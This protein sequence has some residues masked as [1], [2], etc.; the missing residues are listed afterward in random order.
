MAKADRTTLKK[1]TTGSSAVTRLDDF[2]AFGTH[3]WY[4]GVLAEFGA[5]IE[6][7]PEAL[8]DLCDSLTLL[9]QDHTHGFKMLE[10]MGL[11]NVE[12]LLDRI[13]VDTPPGMVIQV[14]INRATR[15][16]LAEYLSQF[17]L[18]IDTHN[19]GLTR[20]IDSLLV[21]ANQSGKLS[22]KWLGMLE[23]LIE[24]PTRLVQRQMEADDDS[25]NKAQ[26]VHEQNI[27][28]LREEVVQDA[29]EEGD[30]SASAEPEPEP[31]S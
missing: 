11:E 5:H 17:G 20:F 3:N 15:N 21:S 7:E 14:V 26:A 2:P 18:V 23:G 29:I 19:K 24:S 27:T 28:E 4:E 9:P 1:R 25:R 30:M 12:G 6:L 16:M 31:S 8:A 13:C 10:R 22:P